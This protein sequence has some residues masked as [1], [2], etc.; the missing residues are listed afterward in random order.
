MI[1]QS[2][3]INSSV[4]K[5][6][7]DLVI[8]RMALADIPGVMAIERESFPAPWPEEAYRHELFN[9][10]K[11]YFIVARQRKQQ[12]Q[13]NAV[14]SVEPSKRNW[15]SRLLRRSSQSPISNLQSPISNLQSLPTVVGYAGMWNMVGE[16]HI[17]TIASHPQ[18]RGRGIG[19]LLLIELLRESQRQGAMN[20]TLEV[21]V[22][23]IAAQ[24]LYLK[25]G[26]EEVGQRKAYYHD[27][28][29]DAFIMTVTNF[30]TAAFADK[31]DGLETGLK[32]KRNDK[33]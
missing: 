17:A 23:N 18:M 8:V 2:V 10:P 33:V 15:F 1:E 27:N 11:A 30:E 31:L 20:V 3:Q 12:P 25:Y 14:R 24:K 26:F 9:N 32:G 22:S 6:V 19:E 4:T 7:T 21:R 5:A 13:P 16:M 28:R 29:E